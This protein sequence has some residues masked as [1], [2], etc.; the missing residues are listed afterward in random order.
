MKAIDIT[1]PNKPTPPICE[2]P[3]FCRIMRHKISRQGLKA[4]S[5]ISSKSR[6]SKHTEACYSAKLPLLLAN[7]GLQTREHRHPYS[8]CAFSLQLANYE[9]P[10]QACLPGM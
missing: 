9:N 4:A 2:V 10:P 7:P 5:H 1:N 6:E 3:F 8:G